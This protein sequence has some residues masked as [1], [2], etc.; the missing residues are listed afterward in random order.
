MA[1]PEAMKRE[2]RGSPE[3][4]WRD[5]SQDVQGFYH[6][7]AW[8]DEAFLKRFWRFTSRRTSSCFTRRRRTKT[9]KS[10]RF[11]TMCTH[12]FQRIRERVRLG[13]LASFSTQNY[14]DDRGV[15][16]SVVF[17]LPMLVLLAL[18]IGCTMYRVSHMLVRSKKFNSLDD[19][20]ATTRPKR[21]E[22]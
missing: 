2:R 19:D 6:A 13:S 10:R 21:K 1:I 3:H 22:N 12:L 18:Q 20:G 8:G 16:F 11:D 17:S 7:V 5:F 9:Y 15:F 14:F 4:A